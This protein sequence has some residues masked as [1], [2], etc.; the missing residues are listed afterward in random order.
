MLSTIDTIEN[1]EESLTLLQE[2]KSP[3]SRSAISVGDQ[4]PAISV[5][6]RDDGAA[7]A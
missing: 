3:S 1:N 7:A 5:Q 2:P 4:R 6:R